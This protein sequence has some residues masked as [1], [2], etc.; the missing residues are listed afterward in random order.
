MTLTPKNSDLNDL[1]NDSLT[2]FR[3]FSKR[4]FV[5]VFFSVTLMLFF[6]TP[7]TK[8]FLV[9][10]LLEREKKKEMSLFSPFSMSSLCFSWISSA[11]S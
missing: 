10:V 2:P 6:I 3:T 4:F 9:E 11:E 5:C 8:A 1:M 7:P